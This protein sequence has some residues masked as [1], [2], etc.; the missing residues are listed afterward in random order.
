MS[1]AVVIVSY[2]SRATLTAALAS[3]REAREVVVVDNAS[4]DGTGAWLARERPYAHLTVVQTEQNVGFSRAVNLGVAHTRAAHVL[5]LNP[6]AALIPGAM[7]QL[8]PRFA[9]CE[10]RFGAWAMGLGQTDPAGALQLACGPRPSLPVEWARRWLQRGLDV[11]GGSRA[12]R[13]ARLVHALLPGPRRVGW[14]AGSSLLVTRRAFARVGGFDPNY[15]LYF[16]DID[17][18][19]RLAHAGGSVAFDPAPL[20]VHHR[21]RSM[22]QAP[23]IAQVAYR[24]SQLR[25]ARTHLGACSA[26]VMAG[27]AKARL[28]RL[29][30][31]P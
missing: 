28:W 21:G 12:R 15:F 23:H 3:V 10:R 1:V 29:G 7:P 27:V 9:A 18:C 2:N 24:R 30:A 16:E 17:F 11:P 6:D 31:A 5:L 19:L 4:P 25:F 20:V 14:V 13:A 26:A 8:L 22:A